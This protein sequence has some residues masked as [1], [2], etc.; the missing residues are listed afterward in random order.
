MINDIKTQTWKI[1]FENVGR[2]KESNIKINLSIQKNFFKTKIEQQNIENK[3]FILVG[4]LSKKS[5]KVHINNFTK[6]LFRDFLLNISKVW[7]FAMDYTYQK[8]RTKVL[9]VLNHSFL[10]F[11]SAKLDLLKLLELPK[12][13]SQKKMF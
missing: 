13:V 7:M 12:F 8:I 5:F 6:N 2:Q 9:K 1:M 4:N 3:K 10:R 11:R